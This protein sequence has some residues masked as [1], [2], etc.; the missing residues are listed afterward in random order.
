MLR[1][2]RNVYMLP[3]H[4][5]KQGCSSMDT[6]CELQR[7]CIYI[8]IDKDRKTLFKFRIV[9]VFTDIHWNN[10]AW[11]WVYL[12][13]WVYCSRW[14]SD[15]HI[16]YWH[17]GAACYWHLQPQSTL[18]NSSAR[19][20]HERK[21]VIVRVLKYSLPHLNEAWLSK[22]NQY[23]SNGSDWT[24]LSQMKWL[25][26]TARNNAGCNL[27]SILRFLNDT[28]WRSYSCH[29]GPGGIP[30]CPEAALKG[31]G[32]WPWRSRQIWNTTTKTPAWHV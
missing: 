7:V 21:N 17:T 26:Y 8:S 24:T 15:A 2:D 12:Q 4:G 11:W 19:L 27:R 31:G 10:R 30:Q 1:Q 23:C 20:K 29:P 32:G 22:I 18:L 25:N 16:A 13:C 14:G 5:T 28:P 3:E 9:F 6:S